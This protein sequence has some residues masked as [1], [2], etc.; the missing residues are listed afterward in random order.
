M[1]TLCIISISLF[2]M[3]ESTAFA[4][5]I[6]GNEYLSLNQ[7]ERLFYSAGFTDG[8]QYVLLLMGKYSPD[9]ITYKQ[10]SDILYKYISL[11]PESRN[12]ALSSL[13]LAAMGEAFPVS[14]LKS[15]K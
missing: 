1:K 8:W 9:N 7:H 3:L 13:A 14:T 4:G 5:T 12:E 15:L 10:V 6:T 11:H 2:L